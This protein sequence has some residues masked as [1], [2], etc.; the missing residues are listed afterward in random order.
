M[1][2]IP[3]HLGV[4][5]ISQCADHGSAGCETTDCEKALLGRLCR[6]QN[7]SLQM[8]INQRDIGIFYK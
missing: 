4:R 5:R 3:R 7:E 1:P 8:F 2:S 6:R